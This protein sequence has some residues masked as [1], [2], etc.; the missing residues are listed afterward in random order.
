M[1]PFRFSF[2]W[3]SVLYFCWRNLICSGGG[4]LPVCLHLFSD[5]IFLKTSEDLCKGLLC[6]ARNP[7]KLCE[8]SKNTTCALQESKIFAT[9]SR[10]KFEIEREQFFD[11]NN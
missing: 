1:N 2:G 11:C 7:V 8:L 3:T 10:W 4:M 9:R 6:N 5:L